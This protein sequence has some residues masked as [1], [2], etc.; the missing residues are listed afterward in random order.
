MPAT[1]PELL[2]DLYTRDE[3]A[4]LDT[5]ADLI[6]RGDVSELDYDNLREYLTDMAIR[7]RKEVLSRLIILIAHHLKWQCQPAG[8]NGGWRATMIVQRSD[9]TETFESKVLRKHAETV[10]AKAYRTAV[11]LAAA[12]TGLPESKFPAKSQHSASEWVALPVPE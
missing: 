9:L 4:W 10:L 12:E 5:M 3:T 2:T 1:A 7:D 6:A 11:E 8:R